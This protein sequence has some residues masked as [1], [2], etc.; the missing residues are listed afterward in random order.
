MWLMLCYHVLRMPRRMG[1]SRISSA[2]CSESG[3][4]C[5]TRAGQSP[6]RF[7]NEPVGQIRFAKRQVGRPMKKDAASDVADTYRAG[8]RHGSKAAVCLLGGCV[9]RR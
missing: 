4:G 7:C 3:R 5:D 2:M 6:R 8:E 1:H 9:S